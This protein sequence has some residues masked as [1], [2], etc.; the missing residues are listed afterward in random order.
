MNDK[1][2]FEYHGFF[3]NLNIYTATDRFFT[4]TDGIG[5][6]KYWM[7]GFGTILVFLMV[8][9]IFS[10]VL[11]SLKDRYYLDH[12]GVY[13]TFFLTIYIDKLRSTFFERKTVN[14]SILNR[15]ENMISFG[16]V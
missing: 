2:N 12:T 16:F 7:L 10:D 4:L 14:K 6:Q 15:N 1:I 11:V 5:L 3:Y 13:L 8:V 9:S